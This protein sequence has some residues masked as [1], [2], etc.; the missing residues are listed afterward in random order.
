MRR[1][2]V[3]LV[4]LTL[5]PLA[6]RAGA[7]G[8]GALG[9]DRSIPPTPVP[10]G[11]GARAAG[12]SNAFI[13]IADDATAASWNPAGLVQL[14]RLEIAI[15]GSLAKLQ[16]RFSTSGHP[17][18][19]GEHTVDG[20]DLNFLSIAG[21]L[22]STVFNRNTTLSLSYQRKFD[23]NRAFG[24]NLVD[25]T[26]APLSPPLAIVQSSRLDFD[27]QGSLSTI[28]P[29][30]AIELTHRLSLGLALNFWRTS[31]LSENSW[32][33]DTRTRGLTTLGSSAILSVGH[34]RERYADFSGENIT[35]GLLWRVN[36]RWSLG[37]RYDSAFT[38]TTSY[39]SFDMEARINPFTPGF[40]PL[41]NMDY[42][43]ER[44]QVRI[45]ATIAAGVAY[46]PNDRLTVALDLSRTDWSH[47]YATDSRGR[48][49]SLVD[50][51]DLAAYA[52]R[53]DFDP[54]YTVRLGTEYVFIPREP[55]VDLPRLWTLRAGLAYEE[56]PASNRPTRSGRDYFRS[57]DGAPDRFYGAS[58]GLGLLL[59]QRVNI[60]VAYQIR[61]GPGVN[62]DLDPGVTGFDADELRHQVLLSTVIYF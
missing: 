56:E 30:I 8:S 54:T 44:R 41:L 9:G 23:F 20:A 36:P 14:E 58:I 48:R 19:D 32:E 34:S 29:A 27:Q 51:S 17:E 28:S 62:R 3:L 15:V 57:G 61:Y 37:M 22:P 60:D 1:V 49:H 38:A 13:A 39:S 18:F 2:A 42:R 5:A 25:G 59:G 47:F 7:Q 40:S 11:S 6:W 45:P 21:P 35:A 55:G 4:L 12:M 33:Q 10:V 53:T 43:S 26:I 16:D 50:G 52:R 46:R 31:F 24:A